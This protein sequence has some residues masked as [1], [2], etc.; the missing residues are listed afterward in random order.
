MPTNASVHLKAVLPNSKKFHQRN[1]TWILPSHDYQSAL[2]IFNVLLLAY[3]MV[4]MN[5]LTLSRI[6]NNEYELNWQGHCI[7]NQSTST[8]NTKRNLLHLHSITKESQWSDF[9]YRTRKIVNRMD[10]H[11]NF[12][13]AWGLKGRL[14]KYLWIFYNDHYDINKTCT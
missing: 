12:V 10:K 4:L 11:V 9:F 2:I 3:Y 5:C 1:M 8:T 13:D 7:F 6:T 14:L